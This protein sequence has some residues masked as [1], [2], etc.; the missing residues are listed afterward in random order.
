MAEIGAYDAKTHL[1]K[2]LE[3][4]EKGQRF[5][6]TKHGRPIAEL[7]PVVRPDAERA[8]KVINALRGLRR[9]LE[10]RGLTLRG[11]LAEGQSLRDLAHY[12]HRY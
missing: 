11:L 5:V 7:V 3:Q 2:L 4:V 8:R 10:R 9:K 12:G 1:S 6:I